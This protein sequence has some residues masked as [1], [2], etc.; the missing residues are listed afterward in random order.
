M[1]TSITSYLLLFTLLCGA[2]M[3]GRCQ[4]KGTVRLLVQPWKRVS[5]RLDDGLPE[6]RITEFRLTP[7][8]HEL[9]FWSK[10]FM[11]WDTTIT[12]Q[13]NSVMELK[14]VLKH[15]PEHVAY[16]QRHAGI[17]RQK[18]LWIGVPTAVT[19]A[20]GAMTLIA[21]KDHDQA[22][23]DL[24]ALADSYG[25]AYSQSAIATLKGESIPEA[26][27]R[28]DDTRARL[29]NSMIVAGVGLAA[30]V[31]GFIRARRLKYPEYEDKQKAIFEGVAWVPTGNGGGAWT[32]GLTIPIR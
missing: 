25:S 9:R 11:A 30:T 23:D 17:W 10:A 28:V 19:I 3:Q 24:H 16:L 18:A 1:R 29:T 13:P 4:D 20:G 27:Q 15:D 22:Y 5:V 21:R 12:V 32:A 8:P 7:G 14:K 26:Q 6:K 31:Y 2:V